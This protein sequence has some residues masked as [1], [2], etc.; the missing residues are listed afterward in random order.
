MLMQ[1]KQRNKKQL[2]VGESRLKILL[3]TGLNRRKLNTKEKLG[4]SVLK[5][6]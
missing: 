1:K 2:R 4:K 3:G 5:L 6:I